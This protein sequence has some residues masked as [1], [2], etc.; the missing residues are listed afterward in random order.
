MNSRIVAVIPARGGSK[1]I[2]RKNLR[3]FCG[4]PLLVHS[5]E[6]A[7]GARCVDEVYVS[8]EDEEIGLISKQAGAMVIKR[9]FELANDTA[10]TF[11]V[12][13]HACDYL[14]S[15]DVLITLQP[16]SPLRTSL[17]IDGGFALLKDDVASVVGVCETHRYHWR[18]VGGLGVPEFNKRLPRQLMEKRY[19]ENG[20]L[21]ISRSSVFENNDDVLGMG[22]SSLGK[23]CLYVMEEEL[24][25]EIDSVSDF[26]IL[27][28]VKQRTGKR[29]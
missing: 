25:M 21:Y 6:A 19:I 28:I 12:I 20:A 9:P 1:G 23:V 13:R 17:H 7:L 24:A 10:S 11:S 4:K 14:N 26:E 2:P 22:I 15:P 5:I 16:T 18:E 3:P 29:R 8:T 27:E